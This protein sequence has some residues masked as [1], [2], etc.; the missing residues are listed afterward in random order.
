MNAIN[1][2]EVGG[3]NKEK[4]KRQIKIFVIKNKKKFEIK[5]K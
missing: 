1:M 5:M 3:K 2:W 4:N